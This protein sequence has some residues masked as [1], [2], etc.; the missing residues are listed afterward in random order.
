[1]ESTPTPSSSRVLESRKEQEEEEPGVFGDPSPRQ[2]ATPSCPAPHSRL[3]GT[4]SI[5]TRP[6][7]TGAPSPP[8]PRSAARPAPGPSLQGSGPWPGGRRGGGWLRVW[9]VSAP[10]PGGGASAPATPRAPRPGLAQAGSRA[11]PRPEIGRA[12]H[13]RARL[14]GPGR[15]VRTCGSASGLGGA[16][17]RR[18]GGRPRRATSGL[19]RGLPLPAPRGLPRAGRPCSRPQQ[20]PAAAAGSWG[21]ARRRGHGGTCSAGG[22]EKAP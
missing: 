1:M 17:R 3:P 13:G 22:R 5:L 14:G 7:G 16:L 6:A 8:P 4:S 11:P 20:C 19:E 9:E 10:G 15:A 12:G 21:C 18:A 2:Q